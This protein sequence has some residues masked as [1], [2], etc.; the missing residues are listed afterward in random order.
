MFSTIRTARISLTSAINALVEL[1][2]IYGLTSLADH[3]LQCRDVLTFVR[4]LELALGNSEE[5]EALENE[6]RTVMVSVYR[7]A[8]EQAEVVASQPEAS[9][10]VEPQASG[11]VEP[12]ASG[13]R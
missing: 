10:S 11:S 1:Q 5:K 12:E 9:G 6:A 2:S 7:T 8:A 4:R 13:S 3:E